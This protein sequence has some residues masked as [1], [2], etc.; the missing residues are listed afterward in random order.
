MKRADVTWA[1]EPDRHASS[2]IAHRGFCAR[3]G[4]PL[5]FEYDE[6]S[7]NLDLTIG[8]FDA[9]ERFRPTHHFGAES[10]HRS[11]LDTTGLPETRSDEYAPLVA[12]WAQAGGAADA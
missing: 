9:P 4:T 7:V 3:C 1:A 5:T 2:A 10:I 12:K 6:G 8:S 11:W